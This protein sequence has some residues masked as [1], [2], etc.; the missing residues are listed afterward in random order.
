VA[1][2]SHHH[3]T[4]TAVAEEV[5]EGQK[6]GARRWTWASA[7]VLCQ[8]QTALRQWSG[9]CYWPQLPNARPTA[10]EEVVVAEEPV[11]EARWPQPIWPYARSP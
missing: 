8:R 10:L 6:A 3:V 7:T 5:A 11:T 4:L 9:Q 2:E 1:L